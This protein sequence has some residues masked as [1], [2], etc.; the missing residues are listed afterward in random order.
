M[1]PHFQ[2]REGAR[3]AHEVR[4]VGRMQLLLLASVVSLHQLTA[5]EGPV[6]AV[7]N[8]LIREQFLSGEASGVLDDATRA[9]LR[10]FQIRRALV[11]TGEIDTATLQALQSN[12]ESA[13]L[14]APGQPRE[15]EGSRPTVA[16]VESDREFLK[17]VE[18]GHEKMPVTL[19]AHA[20]RVQPPPAQPAP[21]ERLIPREASGQPPVPPQAAKSESVARKP[22][23]HISRPNTKARVAMTREQAPSVKREESILKRG[24][25]LEAEPAPP[26]RREQ[27]IT[28]IPSARNS[29]SESDPDI[30]APHGAKIIRSTTT[31]TGPDG[32]TYVYEKK[33]TTFA[34]T[35]P[36]EA[37]RAGEV[38]SQ[39]RDNG[40]LHRIFRH[41]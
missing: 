33:T 24:L 6:S 1:K 9:A 11:A 31:T 21:D 10:R 39:P 8:V 41:D 20:A 18:G 22:E 40:F 19:E 7:Q 25:D 23:V 16:T 30:L 15:S 37:R 17:S 5:A 38:N 12:G 27:V 28:S 3:F 35:P 13:G 36:P 2:I 34:G 29:D 32:R 14:P 26:Q 4:R